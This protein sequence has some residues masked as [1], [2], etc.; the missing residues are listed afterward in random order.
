MANAR[1]MSDED[2]VNIMTT[3]TAKLGADGLVSANKQTMTSLAARLIAL[4]KAGHP[5]LAPSTLDVDGSIYTDPAIFE[6]ERAAIFGKLPY[7]AGLSQDVAKPG[8]FMRIDEFGT[9]T[10][11]TRTKSGTVKAFVNS[12]R[13]RGAALVYEDRGS[14]QGSFT[15]PYHAWTYELDGRLRGISCAG[16]FGTVDK[17]QSGLIEIDATERHGIIFVAPRAGLTIDWDQFIGPELDAELPHWDFGSLAASRSGP[18]PLDGNWKLVLETFLESY[19]FDYAHRDNL[20]KYYIGNC[21]TVDRMGQHLRTCTTLRSLLSELAVKPVE[22]WVPENHI[23]VKYVL[24]PGTVLINTPQVL[25][26]FQVVPVSVNKTIVRH[27]CYSRMDLSD[28]GNAALFDQIWNSAHMV[29]QKQDFPFG[30]TTAQ[31]GLDA[32]LPGLRF[33]RNEWALQIMHGQIN[34]LLNNAPRMARG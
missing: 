28:A 9:P 8:D 33:G 15:C 20:S 30:V 3:M 13:H 19:H 7:V 1:T 23:H 24:F 34:N 29:V 14:V 6:A 21:N 26:F 2:V 16:S 18:I 5:D 12:C 27:H 31:R 17:T 22:Q 25:E 10:L 11:V 32:G 4:A